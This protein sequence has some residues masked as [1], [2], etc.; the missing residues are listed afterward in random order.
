MSK[1]REANLQPP[2]LIIAGQTVNFWNQQSHHEGK[3]LYTGTNPEKFK[4]LG[5]IVH[6]PMIDISRTQMN[7]QEKEEFV[8][9]LE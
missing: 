3:I 5:S 2:A 7:N 8:R 1:V 9:T 4:P 6:L